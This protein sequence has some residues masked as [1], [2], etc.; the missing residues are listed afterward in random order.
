MADNDLTANDLIGIG[1]HLTIL[2]NPQNATGEVYRGATEAFVTLLNKCDFAATLAAVKTIDGCEF[3]VDS[4]NKIILPSHA[5]A[6]RFAAHSVDACLR[7]E[8]TR[9][10]VILSD[11]TP[12]QQLDG[13]PLSKAHQE[14]LRQDLVTC[15]KAHLARPAIVMAWA[16]G[17]DLIRSWVFDNSDRLL[18]FNKQLANTRKGSEPTTVADYHDFFRIGEIRFLEICRDSQDPTLKDFNDKT[19][20][21]CQ[22]MLDQRNEFAHAN[23]S[24]AN[25]SEANSYVLRML[26]ILAGPPF[27]EPTARADAHAGG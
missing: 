16:L 15:L 27:A 18:A 20:R 5:Q 17:Y 4:V 8:A 22:G 23:F 6:L 1:K 26:R 19:L 11:V 25:D 3:Y 14:A 2:N 7:A 12:P 21:G 24:H 13:L 10:T 9:R